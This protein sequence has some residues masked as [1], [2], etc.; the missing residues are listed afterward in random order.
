MEKQLST[1]RGGYLE[2]LLNGCPDAILAI[3]AEGII[4]FANREVC[5][6]TERDMT[7]LVGEN[8][9]IVYEDL[10]AARAINR[11]IYEGGGTLHNQE[12]KL[13][14]KSGK[15]I[16]VRIS[17]SHLHD[18]AG[19]YAGG[20]GYFAPYRPWGDAEAKARDAIEAL[21]SEI[22]EWKE[23]AA[24]VFEL[25]PGILGV[26]VTGHLDTTRFEKIIS[27][28][29]DRIGS[30]K[31]RVALLEL[32]ASE[33][34]DAGIAD[35]L[36]KAIRT[37][38]LLGAHCVISGMPTSLARAI[39]P[40]ISGLASLSPCNCMEMAVEEAFKIIGYEVHKKT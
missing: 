30:A 26:V 31:A 21:E 6:L 36:V 37:I 8:I 10:E 1:H 17:A 5:K 24:P 7:E 25:Y 39:E 23:M 3:D 27:K 4:K 18:S 13:R 29:I 32:S 38:S 16:P 19:N 22:A 12:S 15:L 11:K 40:L 28:L 34:D 20:V 35:Q 2:A 14:T 9:V 33:V